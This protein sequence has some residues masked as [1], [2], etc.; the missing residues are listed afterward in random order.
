MNALASV[1]S[2]AAPS[3]SATHA[4]P[5]A[6]GDDA[7]TPKSGFAHCMAQATQAQTEPPK[8]DEAGADDAASDAPADAAA[9]ASDAAQAPPDLAA[10]LP[11]WNTVAP[12]T[13]SEPAAAPQAADA[14][15]ALL[16]IE[17]KAAKAAA[18][19]ADASSPPPAASAAQ[20]IAAPLANEHHQDIALPSREAAA[21]A[22]A[23]PRATT[24]DNPLPIL[25]AASAPTAAVPTAPARAP[26][27][28]TPMAHLP[29]PIDT[30]SFAPALATQ[31]RWWAAD[32]VQQAQLTLN[33]PEMGPVAVRIVVHEQREAR[34]DFIADVAATR[35]ALEA[36]LPALA[37]ALDESG[38]KLAGGGVHD[39]AAQRQALWQHAQQQQP[40]AA[41]SAGSVGAGKSVTTAGAHA[42]AGAP[43]AR[44]LVDLIA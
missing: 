11:G 30:P 6:E 15:E 3:P 22:P 20:A 40:H 7:D 1:L 35:S 10:W 29:A 33:P 37:A 28:A 9:P 43:S 31:V 19:A 4:A 21:R 14:H 36:A 34:I 13:G 44:G 8:D 38:L 27:S 16:A 26:D 42:P 39:G 5:R 32:G 41:R 24:P 25:P 18:A 17:S 12:V 2:A 23:E